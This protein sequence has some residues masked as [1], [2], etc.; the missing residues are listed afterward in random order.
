MI[1]EYGVP[2]VDPC[3]S[4]AT[5]R[6][7]SVCVIPTLRLRSSGICTEC[8]NRLSVHAVSL[9]GLALVFPELTSLDS[10]TTLDACDPTLTSM[11]GELV[12]HVQTSKAVPPEETNSGNFRVH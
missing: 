11:V 7:S 1:P 5:E 6:R 2:A 9:L 12:V 8:H 10:N 3:S 4:Y